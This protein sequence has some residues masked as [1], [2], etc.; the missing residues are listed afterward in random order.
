MSNQKNIN[1]RLH[2]INATETKKKSKIVLLRTKYYEI[3]SQIVID[4]T[5]R[6]RKNTRK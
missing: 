1:L 4:V 5:T 3:L 2:D 6:T